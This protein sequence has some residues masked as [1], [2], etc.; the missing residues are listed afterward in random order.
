MHDSV[1]GGAKAGVR[2]TSDFVTTSLEA[3]GGACKYGYRCRCIPL[4][5][6]AAQRLLVEGSTASAGETSPATLGG[7]PSVADELLLGEMQ[8]EESV[9]CR[10]CCLS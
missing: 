9:A 3:T 2:W 4:A 1:I 10:V 7:V 5:A 6:S 8:R